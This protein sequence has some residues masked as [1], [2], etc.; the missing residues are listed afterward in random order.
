MPPVP[1]LGHQRLIVTPSLPLQLQGWG[2]ARLDPARSVLPGLPVPISLLTN[3]TPIEE[4]PHGNLPLHPAHPLWA[5]APWPCS[6]G[7]SAVV[8]PAPIA[9]R[10]CCY[11]ILVSRS[12]CKLFSSRFS[13]PC[14]SETSSITLCPASPGHAAEL[15]S[16]FI[17]RACL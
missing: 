12:K 16:H 14:Q 13:F 4:P 15:V 10:W 3:G 2:A 8:A 11:S 1:L 5:W 7:L 17:S 9:N 6:R